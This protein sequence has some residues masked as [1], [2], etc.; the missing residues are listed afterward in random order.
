MRL[1][2]TA[3][4]LIAALLVAAAA[5]VWVNFFNQ[6]QV[7]EQPVL[8]GA[9]RPA[10]IDVAGAQDAAGDASGQPL[11]VAPSAAGG[12]EA[13]G[14]PLAEA[15]SPAAAETAAE[16]DASPSAGEPTA[17]VG[18]QPTPVDPGAVTARSE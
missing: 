18:D 2:R 9:S 8:A 4:F 16:G 17:A 7:R 15:P 13:A 11:G 3:R 12:G 14:Q 10:P 1:S 6:S 5:F